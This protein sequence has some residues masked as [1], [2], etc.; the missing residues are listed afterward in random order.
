MFD[1]LLL[2]VVVLLVN[3]IPAFM[4]PTWAVLSLFAIAYGGPIAELVAVGAIAS[5]LGRY[6]LARISGPLSDRFLPRKQKS[7]IKYLKGFLGGESWTVTSIISFVYS[8]SPLP[9]NTMFIVAGAARI[10]LLPVL[11][12]FFIGRLISYSILTALVASSISIS[13]LLSPAYIVM[14]I[15]GLAAAVALL[16]LDWKVLIH[17]A[18]EHEKK[19]RAEEGVRRLF[20]DDNR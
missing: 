9:S 17:G 1:P 12:G 8:L 14:D 5:T 10:A 20:H 11:G 19:R 6:V 7:S 3:V 2:F 18:I 13:Q 15:I 16:L 4:P